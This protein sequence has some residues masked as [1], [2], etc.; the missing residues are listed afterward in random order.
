MKMLVNFA[1]SKSL[2]KKI[3]QTMETWGFATRAEFFRY[4]AI[5]FLRSDAQAF[6]SDEA[7]HFHTKAINRVKAAKELAKLW[8]KDA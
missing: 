1:I 5:E 7:L 4:C 6:S 8:K 3:D 2:Q